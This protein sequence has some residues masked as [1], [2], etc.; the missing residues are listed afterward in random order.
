MTSRYETEFRKRIRIS[1]AQVKTKKYGGYV[2]MIKPVKVYNNI[3]FLYNESKVRTLNRHLESNEPQLPLPK[4]YIRNTL[5]RQYGSGFMDTV[6][7]DSDNSESE[8]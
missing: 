2:E 5:E 3:P 6:M 4:S 7:S 8:A 1:N